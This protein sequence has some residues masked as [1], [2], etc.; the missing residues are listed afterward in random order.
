MTT[1][2]C[3][4]SG[5]G[6]LVEVDDELGELLELVDLD[7]LI[8]LEFD[9]PVLTGDD[10]VVF[11]VVHLRVVFALV[12]SDGSHDVDNVLLA[13]GREGEDVRLGRGRAHD[14]AQETIISHLAHSFRNQGARQ[15]CL[16]SCW[17][18]QVPLK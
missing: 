4:R 17:C 10:D 1:T 8:E 15:S 11:P 3:G 2:G 9:E 5:R 13:L 18:L 12:S 7:R 14:A 6:R 16:C